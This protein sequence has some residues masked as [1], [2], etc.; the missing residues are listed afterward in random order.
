M[1]ILRSTSAPA[2]TSLQQTRKDPNYRSGMKSFLHTS[3][4]CNGFIRID[5]LVEVTAIEEVLKQF[6]DLGNASGSTNQDDVV[7]CRFIHLGITKSLFHRLQ[8][9]AEQVGVQLLK[10]SPGDARVEIDTFEK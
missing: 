4:I 3:S 6:L 1:R 10:S 2:A 7:D 5:R 8:G 9:A